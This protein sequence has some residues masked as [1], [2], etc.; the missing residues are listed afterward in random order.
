MT[1]LVCG[2][3]LRVLLA[4]I[5]NAVKQRWRIGDECER[6]RQRVACVWQIDTWIALHCGP[7]FITERI[8]RA[9][10]NTAT[11]A[12][13]GR[14]NGIV[15]TRRNVFTSRSLRAIP[16]ARFPFRS[17]ESISCPPRDLRPRHGDFASAIA[18]TKRTDS[19]DEYL[20]SLD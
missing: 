4:R 18:R 8:I 5:R 11:Y 2:V 15:D 3:D 20:E 14:T 13:C 17:R 10:I 19:M 6:E 12:A 9:S 7:E 1:Y 16:S